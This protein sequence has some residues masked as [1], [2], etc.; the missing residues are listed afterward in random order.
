MHVTS[1]LYLNRHH[2]IIPPQGGILKYKLHGQARIQKLVWEELKSWKAKNNIREQKFLPFWSN[3]YSLEKKAK[4]SFG[5][6]RPYVRGWPWIVKTFFSVKF[7]E[8]KE[9][10]WK[11]KIVRIRNKCTRSSGATK[12]NQSVVS[13]SLIIIS[14]CSRCRDGRLWID[15]P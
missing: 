3:A 8:S 10:T 9:T 13:L 1:Y 5:S 15:E 6:R 11:L 7:K 12:Y 4:T 2:S 14:I